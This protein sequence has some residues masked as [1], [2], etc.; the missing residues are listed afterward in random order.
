MC[1]ISLCFKINFE[2][3]NLVLFITQRLNLKAAAIT[4]ISELSYPS[5][6]L[7]LLQGY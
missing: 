7:I 5:G 3:I 2:N 1:L 6:K 4:V